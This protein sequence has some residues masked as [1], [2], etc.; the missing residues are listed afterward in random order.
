MSSFRPITAMVSLLALVACLQL[1]VLP[2]RFANAQSLGSSTSG[3]LTAVRVSESF[4]SAHGARCMDGSTYT[5]YMNRTTTQATAT[6]WLIYLQGGG[7]CNSPSDCKARAQTALGSS[8]QYGAY[9]TDGDNV[10]STKASVNPQ[11]YNWNIVYMPYCSGDTWVGS[12]TDNT[13]DP[14]YQLYFAG[15]NIT[16]ATIQHLKNTQ[17][18]GAATNIVVSGTSAGGIGTV[19]N[20]D[21][22]AAAVPAALTAAYPQ[23]G[24]FT[25]GQS[26]QEWLQAPCDG[27]P[28]CTQAAQDDDTDDSTSIA[29]ATESTYS[30]FHPI[31]VPACYRYYAVTLGQPNGVGHCRSVPTLYKY[32][33]SPAFILENKFDQY[34]IINLKNLP[35]PTAANHNTTLDYFRYFGRQMIDSITA[36]VAGK[37]KGSDG[38]FIPA[39]YQ[40]PTFPTPTA[41]YN[42]TIN[43]QEAFSVFQ[44]WYNALAAGKL[45]PTTAAQY[46]LA[47]RHNHLP[48][49]VCSTTSI[50]S[51]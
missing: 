17:G 49:A 10:A 39:C 19:N 15:H 50:Y 21:Y 9:L 23:A 12:Q 24:W 44:G 14:Q 7:L 18:F 27:N 11:F 42:G 33:Q 8:A 38:F 45:T 25:V 22:F 46:Q 48:L 36:D 35:A 28:Q 34:Q 30:A 4:A 29:A 31:Y 13:T 1:L 51:A 40:H 47:N 41:K 3:E 37:S 5:Y 2:A 16:L 20:V 26:Y 43:G 6:K 32:I